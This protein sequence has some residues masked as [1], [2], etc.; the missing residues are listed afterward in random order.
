[1]DVDLDTAR[2]L[3]AARY[4]YGWQYYIS[5]N[6]RKAEID[7]QDSFWS[8]VMHK[9]LDTSCMDMDYASG[10]MRLKEWK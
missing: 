10:K 3:W 1:M 8:T 2:D 5:L 9:L 7:T 4:G 6:S